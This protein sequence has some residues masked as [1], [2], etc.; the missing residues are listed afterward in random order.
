MPSGSHGGSSGSHSS[1]GSSSGRSGGGGFSTYS[2]RSRVPRRFRWGRSVY[3]IPTKHA[4]KLAIVSVLIPI[5]F[6]ALMFGFIFFMTAKQE[7][8]KIETDY[9]YYQDMIDNAE[10]NPEYMKTGIVTD[11][12]YNEDCDKW[13][14]TYKIQRDDVDWVWLEGYTYSCYTREQVK[15]IPIDSVI[16]IAV[17][18]RDVTGDTDSIPLDYKDMP[19]ERDGEYV[20]A[21]GERTLGVWILIIGGIALGVDIIVGVVMVVKYKE[22]KVEGD[23]GTPMEREWINK[24]DNETKRTTKHCDYCGEIVDINARKCPSCGARL[25]R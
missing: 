24:M 16:Q 20:D 23:F 10:S 13:Y 2:S 17:N 22:K 6:L 8:K 21:K 25:N 19:L 12:F 14:Y 4:G 5:C 7:I 1:G 18:T 9:Y 3:I 11:H 15:Q